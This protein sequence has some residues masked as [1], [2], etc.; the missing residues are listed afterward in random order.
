MFLGRG[1]KL[2]KATHTLSSSLSVYLFEFSPSKLTPYDRVILETRIST[3]PVEKLSNI[4][5]TGKFITMFTK[6]PT[7]TYPKAVHPRFHLTLF[8]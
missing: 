1:C 6:T 3:Q 5:G 8:I 4:F 2:A 7:A